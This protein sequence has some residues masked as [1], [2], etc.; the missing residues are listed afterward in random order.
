ML[1]NKLRYGRAF[2]EHW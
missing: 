2:G 1:N